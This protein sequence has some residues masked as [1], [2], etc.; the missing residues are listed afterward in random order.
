MIDIKNAP[1]QPG[2]YLMK[3]RNNTIIYIGKAKNLK[4]RVKSYFTN[5][6][7]HT[8]KTRALTK[9]ITDIDY[10]ITNTE[11]EAL[12]LEAEMIRKH[13]PQYNIDLKDDKAFPYITITTSETYPRLIISR[14][15]LSKK[16]THFGPYTTTVKSLVLH[17][18]KAFGIRHCNSS[19]LPK[20]VCLSYHIKRCPGPCENNITHERYMENIKHVKQ[21]LKGNTKKTIEDIKDRMKTASENQDFESAAIYR[22][23]LTQMK[24][25]AGRQSIVSREK[26]DVDVI[27]SFSEAG[28]IVFNILLV[29]NG[30][31]TGTRHYIFDKGLKQEAAFPGCWQASP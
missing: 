27:G 1:R 5:P 30:T 6:K 15:N 7:A 4:N 14:R 19:A 23:Q 20:K 17:L 3:N 10:I 22:N 26:T 8:D 18:R 9:N 31:V 12:I 24:I 29:R 13:K 2:I 21:F 25:L 16:D 11:I 28:K